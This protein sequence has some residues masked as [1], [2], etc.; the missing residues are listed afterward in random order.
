[1]SIKAKFFPT[2]DDA[3][4]ANMINED[5]QVV[6]IE[7]QKGAQLD[8]FPLAC[9]A[10]FVNNFKCNGLSGEIIVHIA[11][12]ENTIR[13]QAADF[14]I[15]YC[16]EKILA[17]QLS[18]TSE[19]QLLLDANNTILTKMLISGWY[20]LHWKPVSLSTE[21]AALKNNR[22][23]ALQYIRDRPPV[24]IVTTVGY[25]CRILNT[26]SDHD[27]DA[28]EEAAIIG[29]ILRPRIAEMIHI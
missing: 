9:S 18:S 27:F 14:A 11:G 28:D 21:L 24:D 25:C 22:I 8:E 16:D 6:S 5:P 10:I 7:K 26:T 23:V 29:E 3:V 20:R 13:F 12:T 2:L 19:I 1:M 4:L 15:C 17:A